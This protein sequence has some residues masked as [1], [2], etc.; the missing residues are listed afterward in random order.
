[1]SKI[2]SLILKISFL[3]AIF[4]LAVFVWYSPIIFKGYPSAIP[5]AN[6]II[7]RNLVLSGK[8]SQE[9]SKNIILN[10]ALIFKEGMISSTGDKLIALASALVY[11]IAGL[12]D[13]ARAV[14]YSVIIS[15]LALLF[16]SLTVWRIFGFR[17]AVIF[18]VIYI[19]LPVIWETAVQP[20]LYEYSLLFLSIGFFFFL[21]K[22]SKFEW[23]RFC[24]AGLFFALSFLAR[25]AVALLAPVIFIWLLFY[26]RRAIIPLFLSL[27]LPLLF[28]NIGF[29]SYF[30]K[31]GNYH[32]TYFRAAEVGGQVNDFSFFSH[33]YPDPYTYH[34]GKE[35]FLSEKEND[36]KKGG[37]NAVDI[38][39]R[40]SNVEAKRI[41][42]FEHFRV[43][44]VLVA[45]H[46]S[47]IISLESVGGPL[48]FLLFI[49]GMTNL[50]QSG[51][52]H[53][54]Y[55]SMG[56]ISFVFIFCSFFALAQ[57]NH[58]MDFAFIFAMGVALGIDQL[59]ILVKEKMH[60][61]YYISIFFIVSLAAYQLIL[62]AHVLFGRIYDDSSFLKLKA[63][64][65][66]INNIKISPEEVIA[67]PVNSGEIYG[68]NYLT[69]K[70]VVLFTNKTIEKL[71]KEN[72]LQFAFKE[73]GITKIIGYSPELTNQIIKQTKVV[74]IEIDKTS[75]VIP[76]DSSIKSLFMNLV[77]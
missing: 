2:K 46:L 44:P 55:L 45:K 47:S 76:S 51:R 40:L 70:S 12:P 26:N 73:F 63:Y 5:G 77:R 43:A 32:L 23:L 19:F 27:V 36:L 14:F 29:Q 17:L 11:K 50:I 15:A 54:A 16:F 60:I 48:I 22:W 24:L 33:L 57:R 7:A 61:K 1:M 74:N 65:L 58:V 66:A 42:L 68:L 31:T 41:S 18:S 56:W 72:K 49:L 67:A 75:S 30:G 4:C 35:D 39:K 59:V 52:K 37:L 13:Q 64:Q 71:I 3:A 34:Y 9:N 62:G 53:L 6:Q 8:F 28:F 38:S 21:V 20:N 25:D 10:P 69:D